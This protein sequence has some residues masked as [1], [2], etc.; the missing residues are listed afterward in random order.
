MRDEAE[1]RL[2]TGL[3]PPT[4]PRLPGMIE[5]YDDDYHPDR[6]WRDGALHM[7]HICY[8]PGFELGQPLD[9]SW[10]G[11]DPDP[12]QSL[13]YL[14]WEHSRWDGWQGTLGVYQRATDREWITW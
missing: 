7:C 14:I 1:I 8:G 11:I 10:Y 13:S 6:S 12:D 3:P 9:E 5:I 2:D 4:T